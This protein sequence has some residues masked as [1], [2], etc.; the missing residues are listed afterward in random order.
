MKNKKVVILLATAL[1]VLVGLFAVVFITN[2]PETQDGAK[3][4][5][6]TITFADGTDKDYSISTDAE[7]LG[8]ALLE[9][10][11]VSEE[12]YSKGFYTVIAGERADYTLDGRWW[13]LYIDG[14]MSNLGINEQPIADGD[15]FEITNTP[16]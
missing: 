12:E 7:F 15:T 16:S 2:Q 8:Q 13:G 3:E 6:V 5:A 1:V 10:E 14:E 11:L 4:I 9:E